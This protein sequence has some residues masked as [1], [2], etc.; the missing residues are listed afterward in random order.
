MPL[1]N[2]PACGHQISVEA[3]ACPQCGQETT[4]MADD[5]ISEFIFVRDAP[6]P[7]DLGIVFG[8]GIETELAQRTRQGVNLYRSGYIPRLLF[9]GGTV[10]QM[11]Q[12][13][14]IRMHDL[15]FRLGVPATD[16][17]VEDRSSNTFENAKFSAEVL[18]QRGILAKLASVILISSE[19][20][21]RRVLLSIER[22]FPGNIRFVCCPTLEGC[23]RDNWKH[24]DEFRALVS[25]ES[26]LL[27]TFLQTGALATHV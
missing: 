4:T 10:L 24:S 22:Y 1:I 16:A 8:A 9:T 19:W 5:Q 23:N 13:E 20:H 3:E 27:T 26:L 11:T 25:T 15:A 18:H 7:A 2:C 12:P 6:V 17:L 21:M 14:S